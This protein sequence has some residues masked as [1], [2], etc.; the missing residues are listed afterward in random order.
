MWLL[1]TVVL[2]MS[3]GKQLA[4]VNR[5]SFYVRPLLPIVARL[6]SKCNSGYLVQFYEVFSLY[7]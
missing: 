1:E 6:S 7:E 2:S 5:H 4:A 3:S